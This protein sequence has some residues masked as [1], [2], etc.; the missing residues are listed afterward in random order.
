MTTQLFFLFIDESLYEDLDLAAL[1]GILVPLDRYS[2][3]RDEICKIVADV[4]RLPPNTIPAPIELHV[5][6]LLSDLKGRL[7]SELDQ[8]RLKVMEKV[9]A[10]LNEY[11]L[12]TIRIAY[13]NR[14]EIARMMPRDPKLYSL[15]FF[16]MQTALPETM[17]NAIILP[18]MDGVPGCA[19]TSRHAPTIDPQLIRAFAQ[20]VRWLH[21]HRQYKIARECRL[22]Q[23][24][25]KPRRTRICR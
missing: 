24:C 14:R 16:G 1:T 23:E 2:A 7:Q 25:R 3:V 6:E 4:L 19:P 9:V 18:V 12:T 10:V 17:E 8:D 5:R 15:N 13:L 22:N 11:K 20:S 21:H